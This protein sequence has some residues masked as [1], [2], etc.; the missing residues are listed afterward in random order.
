MWTKLAKTHKREVRVQVRFTQPICVR[1]TRVF[2]RTHV[3]SYCS[4][5]SGRYYTD[6]CH[7]YVALFLLNRKTYFDYYWQIR[8]RPCNLWILNNAQMS[9]KSYWAP[10]SFVFQDKRFE[11]KCLV[12]HL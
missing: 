4:S 1:V 9:S 12:V 6:V 8:C 5:S 7:H 11:R 10:L 3:E 2:V